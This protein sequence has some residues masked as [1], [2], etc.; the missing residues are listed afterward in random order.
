MGQ[1]ENKPV[2]VAINMYGKPYNT[3]VT[4][5]SLL[6]ESH[7]HID[8]I[9]LNIECVQPRKQDSELLLQLLDKVKHHLIVHVPKHHIWYGRL[10]TRKYLNEGYRHSIRYQYAFEVTDKKFLL[11]THNDVLYRKDIVLAFLE[12]IKGRVG[13]GQI[14]MCW[15]CP[16]SKAGKCSSDRFYDY[17]PSIAEITELVS[18][19]PLVREPRAKPV[20]MTAR[21][22]TK[23][24]KLIGA[25]QVVFDARQPWP[26]PECRLNEYSCL[27]DVETIRPLSIPNGPVVPMGSN[28]WLDIGVQWFHMLCNQGYR[29]QHVDISRY[30]LHAWAGD[31]NRGA[32]HPSLFDEDQYRMEEEDARR[33]FE[34]NYS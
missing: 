3:A 12:Q 17:R 7:E 28:E 10:D 6:K 11:I 15:N 9:Y 1:I 4:I 14:G 29:F 27:V 21:I 5:H 26:L 8:K 20:W 24:R 13:A 16:A 31:R 22:W 2:D 34:E 18:R 33:Y 25:P 23:F 32:G 30:C 19:F